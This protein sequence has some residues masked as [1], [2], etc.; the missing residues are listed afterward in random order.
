MSL[1]ISN[2]KAYGNLSNG[3]KDLDKIK[4][5]SH[6]DELL[7]KQI[8][9]ESL[10]NHTDIEKKSSITISKHAQRR[11]ETRN[12]NLTHKDLEALGNAM[13]KAESKGAKESLLIYKDSA[14]I[15]NIANRIVI[16]AMT[17]DDNEE[18]VF[19][20]ID[21]AVFIKNNN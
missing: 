12:I 6:F 15:S 19:T 20:N 1:K 21:S 18:N 2:S 14:F 8:Q 10:K 7:K 9:R 13:D 17:L 3:N 5:N 11:L 4:K 16:T